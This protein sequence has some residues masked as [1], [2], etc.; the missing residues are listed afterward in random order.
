M[1]RGPVGKE[2]DI[3]TTKT[4]KREIKDREKETR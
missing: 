4:R 1:R 3:T 2:Y